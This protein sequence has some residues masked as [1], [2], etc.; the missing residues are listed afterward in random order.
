MFR[1]TTSWGLYAHFSPGNDYCRPRLIPKAY[2][3]NIIIRAIL[4]PKKTILKMYALCPKNVP[5]MQNVKICFSKYFFFSLKNTKKIKT[6]KL[7]CI[8]FTI[9]NSFLF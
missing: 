4:Y 6:F 7:L 3:N 2:R 9:T 5:N 8:Y 1:A